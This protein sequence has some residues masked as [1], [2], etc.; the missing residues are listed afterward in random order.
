M[1]IKSEQKQESDATIQKVEDDRGL[2]IQVYTVFYLAKFAI[3]FMLD[4]LGGDRE[5]NE[6]P[7]EVRSSKSFGRSYVSVAVTIHSKSPAD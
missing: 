7:K 4:I 2:S 5:N 6:S 1:L 3:G